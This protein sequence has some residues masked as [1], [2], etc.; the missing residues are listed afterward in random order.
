[1]SAKRAICLIMAKM[2][3]ADGDVVGAEKDFLQP[4]LD[5]GECVDR[6]MEEAR[7]SPLKE[8]VTNLDNYADRFYVALRAFSMS[9]VDDTVHPDEQRFYE[10]LIALLK[11]KPEDQE[12]IVRTVET[13]EGQPDPRIME[14]FLESSLIH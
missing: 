5:Q 13:T 9:R 12:L 10:E 8:M 7:E 1:M 6:F 2:A 11:I 14:I 4:I 3:M